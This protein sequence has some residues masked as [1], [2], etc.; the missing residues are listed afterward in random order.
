MHR[1]ASWL[2][3]PSMD[4]DDGR[5]PR[6]ATWPPPAARTA[7]QIRASRADCS[8]VTGM[9]LGTTLKEPP[10]TRFAQ[11]LPYV[12]G[13]KASSSSF[14]RKNKH[15][16]ALK[17]PPIIRSAQYLP[18]VTRR[19]SFLWPSDAANRRYHKTALAACM[20]VGCRRASVQS[21]PCAFAIASIGKRQPQSISGSP[22]KIR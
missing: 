4:S 21:T 13:R 17:E 19:M 2:L 5:A 12:T 15:E 22:N 14:I 20:P 10:I 11:Y 6:A 1:P 7:F 18:Y 16:N 8:P 3:P 9:R